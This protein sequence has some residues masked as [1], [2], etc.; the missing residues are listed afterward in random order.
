MPT[1]AQRA[2][3]WGIHTLGLG[4]DWVLP[5]DLCQKEKEPRQTDLQAGQT[6]H[7]LPTQLSGTTSLS[8]MEFI[9]A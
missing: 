5:T 7:W 3:G 1:L 4:R 8:S 2:L 9:V 6:C